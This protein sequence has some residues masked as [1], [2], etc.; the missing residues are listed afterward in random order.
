MPAKKPTCFV[1]LALACTKTD[2][3]AP[4]RNLGPVGF[5]ATPTPCDTPACRKCVATLSDAWRRRADRSMFH[6]FR[7]RFMTVAAPAREAFAVAMRPDGTYPL[8]HCI[9]GPAPSARCAMLSGYCTGVLADALRD[10]QIPVPTRG[11]LV[12]AALSACPPS[13]EAIVADLMVCAPI[14]PHEP[15]ETAACATCLAG[16]LAAASVLA[17]GSDTPDGDGAF[18]ALIT[19]TPEPV[20]RAAVEVLGAP[21]P[22][23]DLETLVVQRTLRRYCFALVARSTAPA[24]YA[25]NSVMLRFLTH[26]EYGDHTRAW[27]ALA[28]ATDTVRAPIVDTLLTETTRETH[29]APSVLAGIR[30]L[31]P[32]G[33]LDALQRAVRS[34]VVSDEAYADLRRELERRGV[35][36]TSLPPVNRPSATPPTGARTPP[37][38]PSTI[39]PPW[40]SSPG[41]SRQG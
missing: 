32:G 30:S 19:S 33:T 34:T 20:A 21:D 37:A 11:L 3:W 31:P 8:E 7:A 27:E 5:T 23:D 36:G 6:V 15:C 35:T 24:P 1:L 17:P 25:C 29:L 16:R 41:P 40:R 2:P 39:P 22:P 13:R 9:A 38:P 12:R 4:C 14:A 28:A 10:G 26:P 18:E